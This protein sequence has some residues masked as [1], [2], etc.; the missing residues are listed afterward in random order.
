MEMKRHR[1]GLRGRKQRRVEGEE[2]EDSLSSLAVSTCLYT[3]IHTDTPA[4]IKSKYTHPP[5]TLSHL[6]AAGKVGLPKGPAAVFVGI[7]EA[8]Q[9]LGSKRIYLR[10]S[11]DGME[12]APGQRHSCSPSKH[13]HTSTCHTRFGTLKGPSARSLSD[14]EREN[15]R[16]CVHVYTC[17]H[18][19]LENVFLFRSTKQQESD[20]K[21]MPPC[22]QHLLWTRHHLHHQCH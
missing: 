5:R 1:Q 10:S 21:K 8:Y 22:I 6:Q 12:G 3:Y 15:E 19:P 13:K 11:W 20:E 9:S 7:C 2:E 16:V 4:H 14:R 17:I 18:T